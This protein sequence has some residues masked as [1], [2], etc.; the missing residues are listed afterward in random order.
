[1]QIVFNMLAFMNCPK[2]VSD[3]L[4]SLRIPSRPAVSADE[5]AASGFHPPER[6]PSSSDNGDD[7]AGDARL[8][9]EPDNPDISCCSEVC[10]APAVVAWATAADCAAGPL[11]LVFC[12]GVTNAVSRLAIADEPAYPYMAAASW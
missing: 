11:L 4:N 1:E 10:C 6:K 3:P 7:E 9:S 8:C 12:C 2:A 5:P